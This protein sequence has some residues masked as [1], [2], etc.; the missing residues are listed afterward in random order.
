[1]TNIT[2]ITWRLALCMVSCCS[3]QRWDSYSGNDELVEHDGSRDR[4]PSSISAVQE[5]TVDETTEAAGAIFAQEF[6][7]ATARAVVRVKAEV[8]NAVDPANGYITAGLAQFIDAL[9]FVECFSARTVLGG[10]F[11]NESNGDMC[12]KNKVR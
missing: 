8:P 2:T 1:M 10:M 4:L 11:R 3:T 6:E 5:G 12:T 7:L 9:P